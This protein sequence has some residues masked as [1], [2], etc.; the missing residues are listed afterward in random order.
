[1]DEVDEWWTPY[2]SKLLRP[3]VKE[4]LKQGITTTV[5]VWGALE[6]LESELIILP[7]RLGKCQQMFETAQARTQKF[8]KSPSLVEVLKS[9]DDGLDSL[10]DN[11]ALL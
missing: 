6:D 3:E 10:K 5:K 11:V 7:H 9:Y 2:I 8:H 1:M 4:R